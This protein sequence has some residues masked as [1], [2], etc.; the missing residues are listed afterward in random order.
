[1]HIKREMR[2]VERDVMLEGALKRP[3][4]ATG[5]WLQSRPEQTVM[6]DEKIYPALDRCV[7]R[8]RGSIDRC[9]NLHHSAGVFDL[10]AVQRV[11]PVGD[12]AGPKE[13][14]AVINQ[15]IELWHAAHCGRRKP[16]MHAQKEVEALVTAG[17]WFWA[18]ARR[19][20]RL[21]G[22]ALDTSAATTS[23]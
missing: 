22:S 16:K 7:D 4:P 17:A 6:H 2:T 11:R 8:T 23:I 5:D 21:L 1:M 20:G 10:Q 9:A 19:G 13:V 3:P 15:L 18:C 14:I 12:F